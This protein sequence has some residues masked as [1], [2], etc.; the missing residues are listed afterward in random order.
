MRKKRKHKKQQESTSQQDRRTKSSPTQMAEQLGQL[1][2]KLF[3]EPENS[4]K[5]NQQ[6]N[7]ENKL[8]DASLTKNIKNTK[9]KKSAVNKN[10]QKRRIRRFSTEIEPS[11]LKQKV[12]MLRSSHKKVYHNTPTP[13]QLEID[14]L[15]FYRK[16][17]TQIRQLRFK[18]GSTSSDIQVNADKRLIDRRL[19][20]A[21][22]YAPRPGG[23]ELEAV[24]G[25][26]FGSTS[27][28]I[29]VRLPFEAGSPTF[30]IDAPLSIQN[31]GKEYLWLNCFWKE[32]DGRYSLIPSISGDSV[33]Y[34]NIKSRFIL[35]SSGENQ[36][37]V[38]VTAYLAMVI[39]Y[40]K[41]YLIESYES[42]FGRKT[43]WEYHFGF[44]AASLNESNLQ[45]KLEKV[46]FAALHIVDNNLEI[47]EEIVIEVLESLS[48]EKHKNTF[49]G[50][51]F[52]EIAGAVSG[53]AN[54]IN[55]EQ[56][57]FC[58]IDVGGLTI[59]CCVFRL[60]HDSLEKKCFIYVADVQSLGVELFKVMENE[61][62]VFFKY[63]RKQFTQ[64]IWNA[65]KDYS[66]NDRCWSEGRGLPYF[67]IG[68]GKQAQVYQNLVSDLNS[69]AQDSQLAGCFEKSLPAGNNFVVSGKNP[70][71]EEDY[72]RLLVAYGLSFSEDDIPKVTLPHVIP[73][74]DPL[75]IDEHADDY[76]LIQT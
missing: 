24:F 2:E 18:D 66:K 54:S 15:D 59:D 37:A 50:G 16:L 13:E 63:V 64:V 65:R 39:R 7:K 21:E 75:V 38:I 53:F 46:R 33:E 26:D 30:I 58:M 41:G 28:K 32:Q 34:R 56:G 42:Y 44:P 52:P 51:V 25:F 73:P 60:S 55:L 35:E 31:E 10:V 8:S 70:L 6:L 4:I 68:G 69:W 40:I 45:K 12:E 9:S 67:F 17:N 11:T 71:V 1:K 72:D 27:S 3:P 20:I 14:E 19:K 23:D 47:K 76:R 29:A 49:M 48:K 22:T 57:L 5:K 74:L 62:L 36:F 61:K 43:N